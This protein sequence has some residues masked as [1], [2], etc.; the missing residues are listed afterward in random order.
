VSG[1]A[2]YESWNNRFEDNRHEIRGNAKPFYWKGRGMTE[3]EWKA[4]PG[5]TDT[6]V[7]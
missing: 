4:G 1:D 3:S 2:V 5:A 6:F 7:R